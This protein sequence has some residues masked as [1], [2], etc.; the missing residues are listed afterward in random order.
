MFERPP[1]GAYDIPGPRSRTGSVAPQGFRRTDGA[2]NAIR[3]DIVG[4]RQIY[5]S[6]VGGYNGNSGGTWDSAKATALG[7]D[8]IDLAGDFIFF[9]SN[10]VESFSAGQVTLNF[11]GIKGKPTK[12]LSVLR[13]SGQPPTTLLAGAQINSD[14]ANTP[15]L[16]FICQ[17]LYCYG[18]FCNIGAVATTANILFGNGAAT[19]F[20]Q[21]FEKC[22]FNLRST[23][24]NVCF[25]KIGQSATN[26]APGL[27]RF[28]NTDFKFADSF[29]SL[30]V[31]QAGVEWTGGSIMSGSTT[32]TVLFRDE[33][34]NGRTATINVS[35]VNLSNLSSTVN[36]IGVGSRR[37]LASIRD[38]KLPA[39]WT[40]SLVSGTMLQSDS[41]VMDNSD[42][43]NTN[44]RKWLESFFGSLKHE[45]TIVRTGGAT[46]GTTPLAWKMATNANA[47]TPSGVLLS[48]ERAQWNELTGSAKTLTVEIV[49]DSQGAGTGGRFRDDEIWL[50]VMALDTASFPL[51]GWVS[52][53]ASSPMT[54][55]D[56]TDS[57][58]AWTT[59]G[60]TSPLKQAL[61]VTVT[62]QVKGHF[63]YR[64]AMASPGKI[65]YVDA[66]MTVT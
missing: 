16:E 29:N 44:Y 5:V 41:V 40:G 13:S 20:L 54:P 63:I 1:L 61:S 10:H 39:S 6:S 3:S 33:T 17:E 53:K 35:G 23:N 4:R 34:A 31:F 49:H 65:C 25:I 26:N 47:A 14:G 22:K 62:P 12:V 19:D 52:D 36:L 43:T 57:A 50:E 15:N 51:G 59:T 58:V 48:T 55:L 37:T 60:L 27:F 9:D 42:A 18:M 46:D 38:C 24:T 56:Q 2:T 28:V 66:M 8:A 64:V 11:T 21:T 45:T 7:A 32:P 30:S